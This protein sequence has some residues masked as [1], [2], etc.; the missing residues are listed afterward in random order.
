MRIDF[1]TVLDYVLNQTPALLKVA[2]DSDF[3][4]AV[5]VIIASA[6]VDC[7]HG[8]AMLLKG[9]HVG[10]HAGF[11]P[12]AP[13]FGGH[14]DNEGRA[15]KVDATDV[16]DK[17]RIPTSV[18]LQDVAAVI[19]EFH[20]RVGGAMTAGFFFLEKDGF[21]AAVFLDGLQSDENSVFVIGAE[22][23]ERVLPGREAEDYV[24][25][26]D[27]PEITW[28]VSLHLVEMCNYAGVCFGFPFP[29][30]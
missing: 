8:E 23:A 11:F 5:R 30:V 22:S 17:V 12:V 16:G 20:F 9:L 28:M 14:V 21:H 13:A 25:G 24:S 7:G 26:L 19:E 3:L 6:D 10:H 2:F 1:G 15:A 27:G 29:G 18:A 4:V